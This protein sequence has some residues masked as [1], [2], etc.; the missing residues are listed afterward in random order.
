MID[1]VGD[2]KCLFCLPVC[3][4]ATCK[5]HAIYH[6]TFR[7]QTE[8]QPACGPAHHQA[9]STNGPLLT[10]TYEFGNV[11]SFS[12]NFAA[13]TFCHFQLSH[14]FA[15]SHYHYRARM[16][17]CWTTLLLLL[18]V[19][20]CRLFWEEKLEFITSLAFTSDCIHDGMLKGFNIKCSWPGFEIGTQSVQL[21][22]WERIPF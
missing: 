5:C 16:C 3:S 2:I 17:V 1:R 8:T 6:V 15:K 7:S 19:I 21:N 11:I 9:P 14:S 12:H 18:R 13:A 20:I 4:R 22:R 10:D